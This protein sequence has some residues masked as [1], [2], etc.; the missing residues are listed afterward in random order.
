MRAEA[1]S[2]CLVAQWYPLLLFFGFGFPCK[3]TKPKKGCPYYNFVTGLPRLCVLNKKRESILC[4]FSNQGLFCISFFAAL[5]AVPSWASVGL[6]CV[7][8]G[9]RV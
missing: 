2:S 7:G 6:G 8:L 4:S 3:V 9:F 1:S 5:S